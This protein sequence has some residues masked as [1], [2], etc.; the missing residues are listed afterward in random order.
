MTF[1]A[2]WMHDGFVTGL[3]GPAA[4]GGE[5]SYSVGETRIVR[6]AQ[7]IGDAVVCS[8]SGRQT[9]YVASAAK[10]SDAAESA[11]ASQAAVARQRDAGWQICNAYANGAINRAQ[12]AAL[13]TRLVD[14]VV[15]GGRDQPRTS[16]IKRH[17]GRGGGR[18]H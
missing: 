12:Y 3:H 9:I 17:K 4:S 2:W 5:L 15:A 18:R 14:G 1:V 11:R 16:S 6:S 10:G 13:L 8:E 7:K